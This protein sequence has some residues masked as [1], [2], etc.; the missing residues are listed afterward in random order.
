MNEQATTAMVLQKFHNDRFCLC[1]TTRSIF[2]LHPRLIC[3]DFL[4]L[5]NKCVNLAHSYYF[6]VLAPNTDEKLFLIL[7]FRASP[8]TTTNRVSRVQ[9]LQG[10]IWS[11][12][13]DS[14]LTY[15]VT[16]R[17]SSLKSIKQEPPFSSLLTISQRLLSVPRC[18]VLY[19]TVSYFIITN[20]RKRV[21]MLER[22]HIL[23][24]LIIEVSFLQFCLNIFIRKSDWLCS[25][26]K[27]QIRV[28]IEIWKPLY[29]T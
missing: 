15:M 17:F 5:C 16:G 21:S 20:S 24:K 18:N 12:R 11:G 28:R 19:N 25:K 2:H 3:I 29:H 9:V 7:V 6:T 1:S 8:K 10:L 27:D 4:L 14:K 26:A 23:T 13:C 22:R